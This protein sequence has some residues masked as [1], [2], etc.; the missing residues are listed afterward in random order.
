M[1]TVKTATKATKTTKTTKAKKAEVVET[2]EA[3]ET[4]S[5]EALIV[6]DTETFKKAIEIIVCK[7]EAIA[8]NDKQKAVLK[9]DI[10]KILLKY[11]GSAMYNTMNYCLNTLETQ[12]GNEVVWGSVM[13]AIKDTIKSHA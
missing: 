2:I 7:L 4:Q 11:D 8:V 13:N 3:Q 12:Q 1:A 10:D 9:S 5:T 6:N